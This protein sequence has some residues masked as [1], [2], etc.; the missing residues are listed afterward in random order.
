[1]GLVDGPHAADAELLQ[2]PVAR[3][4]DEPRGMAADG[5]GAGLAAAATVAGVGG[6]DGS[7]ERVGWLS[8]RPFSESTVAGRRAYRPSSAGDFARKV[9]TA[10]RQLRHWARCC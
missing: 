6:A 2:D 3:V 10:S 9:C 5:L 8:A 1:L 7:G 4:L